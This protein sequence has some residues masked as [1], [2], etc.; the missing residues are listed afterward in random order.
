MARAAD[1]YVLTPSQEGILFESLSSAGSGTYVSQA[2]FTLENAD[3]ARLERAWQQVVDRHSALRTAF[4]WQNVKRPLQVVGD[5][6]RVPF[7]VEDWRG[8][9]A[10][11]QE[12]RL[13]AFLLEDRRAGFSFSKPPL[14]RVTAFRTGDDRCRLVWTF[15]HIVLDG[16]S[17]G[18]VLS[19]LFA[20]EEALRTG[21]ALARPAARPFRDYVDWLGQ[22]DLA[23]AESF[24]RERLRGFSAPTSLAG[25]ARVESDPGAD[26]DPHGTLESRLTPERTAAL[27]AAARG[28]HLTL[29]TLVQGVWA[30]ALARW[31]GE[32]RVTYGTAVAGRPAALAGVESMVGLFINTLPTPVRVPGAA[33]AGAWLQDLQ[34]EQAELREFEW[35]PLAQVQAWSGAARGTRLF[36]ALLAFESYPVSGFDV[37]R[38]PAALRIV[39]ARFEDNS[40][41]PLSLA[42]RPG[43]ELTLRFGYDRRRFD[44]A[45]VRRLL[46]HVER[47]FEAAATSLE[48]RVAELP[49]LPAEEERRLLVEWSGATL[50][51]AP[52]LDVLEAFR[53]R[54]R[55]EPGAVAVT[56]TGAQITYGELDRRSDRLAARLAALGVGEEARVAVY[57]P[58][59]IAGVV[60]I[61]AV[62]KTGAAYLP[63]DPT[64]PDERV[65]FMLRDAGTSAVLA[66]PDLI[67]P[68]AG[69][70]VVA[71]DAAEDQEPIATRPMP[72]P[73][74]LAY[75]I[76][77]SGST[78][79]PRGVAVPHRGLAN[80]VAW[81]VRA[82]GLGPRDRT[83]LVASPAF[84]ASAWELWP[85]LASG[86]SLEVPS[87][88]TRVHPAALVAWLAER[89][90][91]VSFLPTPLARAV[92]EEPG[93]E[94][95][96]LRALLTGGDTLHRVE[97]PALP[98]ALVNHYGPTENS[99]VATAGVVTPGAPG[100]PSIGRAIDGVRVL[101][102]DESLR[103]VPQGVAGELFVGG[104][105][106][107]RGYVGRPEATALAFVPDPFA[108]T[109]GARLYR[110]GDRVRFRGD[111]TLE[112][113]GRLD[114]QVKV[115]GFRI[116]LPEIE[117]ALARQPGVEDVVV[118]ATPGPG[119]RRLA[120]YVVGDVRASELRTALQATLPG[121]MVPSAI[122]LMASLP[123]S[124]NGKVDRAAL[125]APVFEGEGAY[126]APRTRA[127]TLLARVWSDVLRAPVVGIHDDFF[128]LGGDS[129]L[130]VQVVARARQAGLQVTPAQVF[131][132]PSVAALAS[133]ARETAGAVVPELVVDEAERARAAG[134]RDVEDVYPLSPMQQGML[135]HT[136]VA[137]SAGL[138]VEQLQLDLDA[139]LDPL[140]LRRAW[141]D[142]VARHA[143]FRTAFAWAGL[144]RPLQVVEPAAAL[145]WHEEDWS[146]LAAPEQDERM[147]S[148]LEADARRGF[149]PTRAPLM[150]VALFHCGAAGRRMVW[151]F[152]HALIDGWC[153]SLVMGDLLSFYKARA[154]N[155]AAR[156]ATPPRYRD[157]IAWLESRDK[158]ASEAHWRERLRGFEGPTALGVDRSAPTPGA[159]AEAVLD[160]D[161]DTTRALSRLGRRH[162]LT[163]NT[164]VQG[165]WALLLGRYSGAADVTFGVTTSGRPPALPGV[166]RMVGLFITTLPSRVDLPDA[167]LLEAW[168]KD[169]QGRQV[170]DREHLD[171]PLADIQR[172]A[173]GGQPLFE[174][175]LAFENYAIDPEARS[176]RQELRLQGRPM[177]ERLNYPLV[178]AVIPLPGL[179]VRAL[180]DDARFPAGTVARLLAHLRRLLETFAQGLDR[181]LGALSLLDP[182]ERREQLDAAGDPR[183][184]PAPASVL[185]AVRA[186]AA[187]NPDAIAVATDDRQLTYG[188]LHA[189]ANRLARRLQALGAAR[190]ARI[191][192][193]LPRS[194]EMVVAVLAVLKTGAAYVALDPAYPA[195]RLEFMVRD[196]RLTALVSGE[197]SAAATDLPRLVVSDDREPA[198]VDAAAVDVAVDPE[199]VAYI[200]Y[201]SGSTGTP[202]GVAV[203]HRGLASLVSWHLGAYALTAEDRTT[204]VASPAFDASVW[205]VWPA[206]ASGASLWIPGEATRLVP[207]SLV[208]WLAR[209]AVTVTFLPTPLAE[210]VLREP[211]VATLRSLRLLLTGGDRL[212][213]PE[214]DGLPFALVNHYGPTESSVVSTAGP[215]HLE[216]PREPSIGRAIDGTRAYVLDASLEPVPAGVP[217]EL[218][219][220]GSSLAR[221]YWDRPDATA[222]RFVPDPFASEPGR[223]LYRTGDRVRRREDGELEFLERVD[224]QVKV[225]GFRIELGEIESVLTAHP[226]VRDVVVAA[227]GADARLAAYVVLDDAGVDLSALKR[228]AQERLP[229]YMVPSSITR[230]DAVPLTANGK[231][232][233]RA[234][235]EPDLRRADATP[236]RDALEASLAVAWRDVLGLDSV[237]VHD[238]FFDL[239]G[240]S[241]SL[242]RLHGRLRDVVAPREISVVEL[243]EH[244]TIADLAEHLRG[245]GDTALAVAAE[246][247]ERLN[248]GRARLAQRRQKGSGA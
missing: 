189:A 240:H 90:I 67:V 196:A 15:H 160:L 105:G 141:E 138:Y 230:I 170:E 116:E 146:A 61:L 74:R 72:D 140:L 228:Y 60:A 173:G 45:T 193:C 62:V 54:A 231:R 65:A 48:T 210:A 2:I 172:G 161:V 167:A 180:Y 234:L 82:Y 143:I 233:R 247:G 227:R 200:I 9:D 171:T 190:G 88:D 25:L 201:T 47:L 213:R 126:E 132:H 129:I 124:S 95:L 91:A 76:Y 93:L 202:K 174:S 97:R 222:D 4:A 239:G 8:V 224:Q 248:E 98:F 238:S 73:E 243:F 38:D 70:P 242:V 19:E 178:L 214:R 22:T 77:T 64:Y 78:G 7:R 139:A 130:S 6:V 110:T 36:E 14:L 13:E 112:F 18:I 209:Q 96:G 176:L 212:H 118:V 10:L 207:E 29:N 12:R 203:P 28:R 108:D 182:A 56:E 41:Y 1:T 158:R 34:A 179:Q 16:W 149:D 81:H 241:L 165:A 42:V 145:P 68:D 79:Q 221:G 153:F 69:V 30:V 55:L 117:A 33:S 111:G 37:A 169:L 120:A 236:P 177:L 157:Y 235:P 43:P 225:R 106:L 114:H 21:R 85:A 208:S 113:L 127:E 183:T 216:D 246:R 137:P 44:E 168:L 245:G 211:A 75:V 24:W 53:D 107:A 186:V 142:V 204:L 35:S 206:L 71:I 151:T 198:G 187:R 92:L 181:P 57:A 136:L 162:G 66:P 191:G 152:H 188:E 27:E 133:V 83:T 232:D 205:E 229:D 131:A 150:R 84:D 226:A 154:R 134:A 31:T 11:E 128:E 40:S 175:L 100:D 223:R 3:L 109:P 220:G 17:V 135:F 125:P 86:A 115:R 244:P 163:L 144:A 102:L 5:A 159:V 89:R 185:D 155:V 87:D 219:V 197:G 32:P 51:P 192:V 52:A 156:T 80:L 119:E 104:A 46:G 26:L 103:P 148:F 184:E 122:V 237:G 166:E 194:I 215:V 218:Y 164:F 101:V 58:R 147:R 199:D 123:Q 195:A 49:L 59:S 94:R 23:R 63:I 121:Y 50:V 217:G 39:R 20:G 99:V